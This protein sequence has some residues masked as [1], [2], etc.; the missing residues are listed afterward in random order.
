LNWQAVQDQS[1]DELIISYYHPTS[2]SGE[3]FLESQRRY[4]VP[5]GTTASPQSQKILKDL[6][7]EL[8][9][10]WPFLVHIDSVIAVPSGEDIE[11][12]EITKKFVGKTLQDLY[13][14]HKLLGSVI[15][16][17]VSIFPLLISFFFLPLF[18]IYFFSIETPTDICTIVVWDPCFESSKSSS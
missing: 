3:E 16:V 17:D 7:K 5:L 11:G 10:R 8:V 9:E 18:L 14:D 13:V 6:K 2:D 1:D 4:I 12:I 15:P